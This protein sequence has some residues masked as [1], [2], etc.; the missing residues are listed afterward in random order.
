[1]PPKKPAAAGAAKT[2]TKAEVDALLAKAKNTSDDI[3]D[4][5]KRP[6]HRIYAEDG[7]QLTKLPG[8]EDGG[9]GGPWTMNGLHPDDYYGAEEQDDKDSPGGKRWVATQNV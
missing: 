3:E 9:E 5:A 1:M 8:V 2:Y 6:Y 4:I 7:Q